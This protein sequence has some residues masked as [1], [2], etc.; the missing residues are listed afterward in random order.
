MSLTGVGGADDVRKKLLASLAVTTTDA[1][2]QAKKLGVASE[3]LATA[4]NK[5]QDS[6]RE[7]SLDEEP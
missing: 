1:D 6:L 5:L 3:A 7:L 2:Q 4:R